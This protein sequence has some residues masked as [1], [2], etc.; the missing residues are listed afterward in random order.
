MILIGVASATPAIVQTESRLPESGAGVTTLAKRTGVVSRR[1]SL[2]LEY[3]RE[4]GNVD[5]LEGW[6]V[7]TTTPTALGAQAARELLQRAE[8]SIDQVGLVLGDTATPYQTCPSE[9]QRIV[10]EFGVKTAA[11]DLVGGIGAVPHLFAVLSRWSEARTP[12][13]L[14]YVSTNTPSQQV[15]YRSDPDAAGLF[16]DAAVA[17]LFSKQPQAGR[18]SMRLAFNSMRAEDRRRSPLIIERTVGVNQQAL[19][20]ALEL[21]SFLKAELENLKSF[22]PQIAQSATFVAPQLYAAEAGAMLGILGVKPQA[23]VSGV[24]DVGFSLG[25]AHGVA[26][27]RIWGDRDPNSTVVLMHCGD[28][29]CGSVVL[30]KEFN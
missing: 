7:A 15:D 30:V 22:D 2:P 28:G 24:D 6:K 13:Y 14:L 26:L 20:S 23:I 27:D 29:Q 8:L 17:L 9:A 16:G 25:S 18:P 4:T 10:S 19:L 1:I 5:P 12:Q 11:F 3:I 21:Q